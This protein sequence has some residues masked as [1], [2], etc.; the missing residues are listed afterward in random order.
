MNGVN[1]LPVPTTQLY[2]GGLSL[3][4]AGAHSHTQADSTTHYLVV[5]LL[6]A[7]QLGKLL[8]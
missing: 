6:E 8:W 1:P 2:T 7:T 4:A 3:R 5:F